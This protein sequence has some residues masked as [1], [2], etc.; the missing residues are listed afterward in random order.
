MH[1]PRL[2]LLSVAFTLSA[3]GQDG[4]D[5]RIIL[6]R[7][8]VIGLA[9]GIALD[10]LIGLTLGPIALEARRASSQAHLNR[11]AAYEACLQFDQV[12]VA[13]LKRWDAIIALINSGPASPQTE[14]FIKGVEQANKTA[15]QPVDCAS[16]KP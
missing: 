13:D 12:K 1:S 4:T 10:L 3:A 11:V 6:R 8:V 2:L 15:D 16:I 5:G 7:W 14:A 9:V